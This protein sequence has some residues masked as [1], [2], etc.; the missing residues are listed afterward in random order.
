VGLI[1]LDSWRRAAHRSITWDNRRPNFERAK[2]KSS[3]TEEKD[4]T[5]RQRPYISQL[6]THT[7][8]NMADEV[9]EGAIG[10]DLGMFPDK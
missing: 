10:I 9:Y 2:V 1:V 6:I 5:P 8:Y 7:T 4:Q 3:Q